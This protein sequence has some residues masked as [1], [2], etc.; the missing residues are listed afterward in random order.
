MVHQYYN[1]VIM[2]AMASQITS[3]T[4]V[5]PSV[6]WKHQSSAS[7]A[8]MRLIH[9]RPVNSPHKGQVTRKMD[10][11]DDVIMSGIHI[12]Q[13]NSI[14]P[15]AIT[16][17]TQWQWSSHDICG[18]TS[19]IYSTQSLIYPELNT[20]I[21]INVNV[22]WCVTIQ[23]WLYKL[24]IYKFVVMSPKWFYASQYWSHWGR[25]ANNWAGI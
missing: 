8:V 18:Y 19:H 24:C 13:G 25:L 22:S 6:Y 11:F 7:L 21:S 9:R 1:G 4:I 5:Y 23:L 3:L 14:V 15:G 2:S 17:V 10:P 12:H 20:K 16:C